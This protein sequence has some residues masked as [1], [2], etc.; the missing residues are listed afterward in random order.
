M[1][2]H[3]IISG[4]VQGV[5]FRRFVKYQA[6][7]LGLTGWV[8]NLADNR[9]EVLFQGPKERIEMIIAVCKKGSFFS[10][11]KDLRVEWEDQV[12]ENFTSFDIL[13]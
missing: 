1:V 8:K 11:V 7:K 13:H 9:V 5:G 6:L 2:A 10:E 4:F 12:T 3:V